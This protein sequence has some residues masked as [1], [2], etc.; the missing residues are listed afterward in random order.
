MK[1]RIQGNS[2]RLRLT[3]SEVER[4]REGGEISET[5]PIRT[6]GPLTYRLRKSAGAD[7]VQAELAQG[8]ISVSV[9]GPM[10]ERWAGSDD[11]GIYGQEGVLNIAIEKDFRCLTRA[12]EEQEADA[13]P[14]PAEQ[15]T[16]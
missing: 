15:C 9:P 1:L 11:I 10:V 5:I 6:G 2:L 8:V 14:H 16:A 13:Y 7:A 4:L 12:A 3:R